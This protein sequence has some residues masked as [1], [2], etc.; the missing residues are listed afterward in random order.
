M[1]QIG[2]SIA[3]D[4]MA[5]YR[6]IFGKTYFHI[7]SLYTSLKCYNDLNHPTISLLVHT[8]CLSHLG[9][10]NQQMNNLIRVLWWQCESPVMSDVTIY[11][12]TICRPPH[13]HVAWWSLWHFCATHMRTVLT[14]CS[15]MR[16]SSHSPTCVWWYCRLLLF[17][18]LQW[19]TLRSILFV[20]YQML[21]HIALCLTHHFASWCTW[22]GFLRD[23]V[24]AQ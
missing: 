15:V 3:V 11:N 22:C 13:V 9:E 18:C 20:H 10:H 6:C 5:V 2:P 23:H 1:D 4:E 21:L 7:L 12:V 24:Y 17:S 19:R 16:P 8:S 14:S